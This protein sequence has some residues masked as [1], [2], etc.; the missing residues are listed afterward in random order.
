MKESSKLHAFTGTVQRGHVIA[1][2]P[3]IVLIGCWW[4]FPLVESYVHVVFLIGRHVANPLN[5][6]L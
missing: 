5:G 4:L 2:Y 1:M 3:W 6:K